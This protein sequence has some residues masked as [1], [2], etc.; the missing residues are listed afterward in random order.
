MLPAARAVV[1]RVTARGLRGVGRSVGKGSRSVGRS[2]SK[3][4]R[5][6]G[7]GSKD[8]SVIMNS[9]N[10]PVVTQTRQG[11]DMQLGEGRK[12]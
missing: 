3:G 7:Q 2:A 9:T 10:A 5:G 12:K 6:V 4:S 11:N 8:A 1:G